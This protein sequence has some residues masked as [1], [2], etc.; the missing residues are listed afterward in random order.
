MKLEKRIVKIAINVKV[1]VK[2]LSCVQLLATPWTAA[3]EA[4][5]SMGFS[6]Q[7]QRSGVPKMWSQLKELKL[8]SEFEASKLPLRTRVFSE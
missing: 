4:P 8:Q 3:H 5:P 6:R 7:E 2:S 1:K